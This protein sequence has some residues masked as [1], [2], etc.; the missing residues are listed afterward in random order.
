MRNNE[1]WLG[2]AF[3]GGNAY[4][5]TSPQNGREFAS[6][7]Y[8]DNTGLV[9]FRNVGWFT[10]IEHGSRHEWMQLDTMANNLKHN[11]KLR[12]KIENE[13]GEAKYQ[14]Y[15]NYDAI[16][17]PFVE[18]IPSDYKGVMGVPVTFMD[19][20]NPEQFEILGTSDNGIISD[21]Y[22][23]TKGLTKEAAKIT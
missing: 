17:V 13:Y 5:K 18:C 19:K 2:T 1:I 23:T 6:G 8:D 7:V 4:F 22:K 12:R 9:K 21:E 10:N 20:Y 3:S 11:K 16:E 14:T 15:D